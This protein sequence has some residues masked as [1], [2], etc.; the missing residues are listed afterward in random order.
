MVFHRSRASPAE[1][2]SSNKTQ[3][4]IFALRH[5][6]FEPTSSIVPP[7][8]DPSPLLLLLDAD[9]LAL[10][11]EVEDCLTSEVLIV[12]MADGA[13]G[14]TVVIAIT[15]EVVVAAPLADRMDVTWTVDEGVN[16]VV[17]AMLAVEGT[18]VEGTVVSA[19]GD[20]VV[21]TVVVKKYNPPLLCSWF[22]PPRAFGQSTPVPWFWKN[23]PINVFG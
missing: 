20:V 21:A 13:F 3:S 19:I 10:D 8:F 11:V 23:D 4:F 5:D 16:V 9:V 1:P 18:V 7:P 15:S 17:I 12:D 2:A 22:D 14:V 6:E